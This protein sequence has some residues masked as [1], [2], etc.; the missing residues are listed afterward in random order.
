M[1]IEDRLDDAG[2]KDVYLRSLL[3]P[4]CRVPPEVIMEIFKTYCYDLKANT[5]TFS[6]SRLPA[7]LALS[8]L[9]SLRRNIVLSAPSL[10]SML[11]VLGYSSDPKS[12]NI[13][14]LYMDR[15]QNAPLTLA[16]LNPSDVPGRQRSSSDIMN[17]LISHS[18]R[19]KS[20]EL[21]TDGERS[22]KIASIRGQVS[23]LTSLT[24]DCMMGEL[25]YDSGLLRGFEHAPNLLSVTPSDGPWH[26]LEE[27]WLLYCET[28]RML[29]LLRTCT[30]VGLDGVSDP[31]LFITLPTVRTLSL[32]VAEARVISFV[33]EHVTLPGLETLEVKFIS[34]PNWNVPWDV[35]NLLHAL[36][37]CVLAPLTLTKAPLRDVDMIS[38]L[39]T[40]PSLGSL[41]FSESV[42]FS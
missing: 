37:P 28:G 35:I 1:V 32:I 27:V 18:D 21:D 31:S 29:E 3:S 12:L 10:W 40:I 11:H 17:I 24:L 2:R 36:E 6:P 7:T 42:P 26:Q 41:S 23:M 5:I 8:M 4:I 22:Q 19:W 39:E 14:K 25:E 13:T 30:S 9:C 16:V 33:F 34:L 15:S 20:V 38:I